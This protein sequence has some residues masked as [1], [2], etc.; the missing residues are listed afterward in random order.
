MSK[1]T[2]IVRIFLSSFGQTAPS[3]FLESKSDHVNAAQGLSAETKV[4]ES[5]NIP[6]QIRLVIMRF[7]YVRREKEVTPASDQR[8]SSVI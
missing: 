4:K 7:V 2:D 3:R 5:A 6:M 1:L 8:L